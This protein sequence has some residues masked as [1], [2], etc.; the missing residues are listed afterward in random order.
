MTLGTDT[1]IAATKSKSM[2][3]RPLNLNFGELAKSLAKG[4][5]HA[6]TGRFEELPDDGIDALGAIGIDEYSS[7]SLTYKLL[8][9]SLQSSIYALIIDSKE[10]IDDD[11]DATQ[12]IK[13][14]EAH[15]ET[16]D[17]NVDFF[18]TPN[19]FPVI[20]AT[21][22]A[23]A[24]WLMLNGVETH[25]A[26]TIAARLPGYFP[27]ALHKEW[28][29]AASKYEI[30]R[31]DLMSPFL[32]SVQREAAWD[33]YHASLN[34]RLDESLFGE[35]FGL[36]QIYIPLNSYYDT[37]L[38]KSE[39]QKNGRHKKR[40]VVKLI[41][42]LDLWLDS[43]KKDDAIRAI[44]GGP[45][46][47]KS[48]FAK[49]YA[50][51]IASQNKNKVLFVPLHY[52]DPTRDFIEEIGR[53][54]RDEGILQANPLT[55]EGRSSDLLIILDGL[56]ELSSQ[57]RAAASTARNFVR[58]V[59]QTVDR[60][61]MH[62]LNLRVIFSGREV[63][64]QDSE[65]EF[66]LP[67]QVLTILPYFSGTKAD[68]D[69]DHS[70]YDDPMSLL[71]IDYRNIWWSNYSTLT[72]LMYEGIPPELDRSDLVEITSQPLLNYLL[73]LSFCR[74]KLN[75]SAG[76]NLNQIYE[77]LVQAVYERGYENG[78]KPESIRQLDSEDFGL[79]LEEIGLASWHGDGRTTTVSEIENYCRS[80]G[81]GE[82]LDA[83]QDGAKVGIT[84]LLAAFFFRQHGNRPQGDPTFIF[85][86]KSFGEYLAARRIV[87][88]MLVI[89][90]EMDRRETIGRGR[91]WSTTDALVYWAE[92]SG[93]TALSE[94]IHIFLRSEVMLLTKTQT[95]RAQSFFTVLLN[96]VLKFGMPIEK[97]NKIK[98]F[99]DALHNSRNSEEALLAALNAAA[100]ANKAIT[101]LDHPDATTF[102]SWFK[103]IQKQRSGPE[104]CLAASC[105]SWL[106]LSYTNLDF[107]DLYGADISYSNLS[108]VQGFRI[109]LSEATADHANFQ[110]AIFTEGYLS[111]SSFISA[112]FQ[113]AIL[114][115]ADFE[116]SNCV[117]ANF[118]KA[119]VN[120]AT[121]EEAALRGA[122]F[123]GSRRTE[124][125][126]PASRRRL[127]LKE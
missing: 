43:A 91:G 124:T 53:F 115:K 78:R 94:N 96:H 9:R 16:T 25:K 70:E 76:V 26:Q 10:Q 59:Q 68:R 37:V 90:D 117:K 101:K 49:I 126:F 107:A 99:H 113:N 35:P 36:R 61:N 46:S 60:L 58:S 6:I 77:D 20:T 32:N 4:I 123:R 38:S 45:G 88:S 114:A 73:A 62:S 92:T 34:Q 41:D 12:F 18:E 7:E 28:Q 5:G 47:G 66:R 27:L 105:L 29:S 71:D 102:G 119:D 30:I 3:S 93:P 24:E 17:V 14:L 98:T 82:Q 103:R 121:F 109:I 56:D 85:T 120:F 19:Q 110:D 80:G 125:K 65:S 15:I 33:I 51:H 40:V 100:R 64:M 111:Y 52:I 89:I 97:I 55:K 23:L 72:G 11:V 48:S 57:G 112:N 22:M 31:T 127:A 86:H 39:I 87:R 69:L 63:V 84:S 44:S 54:V 13:I 108:N 1:S 8:E 118:M 116:D 95:L 106:D 67:R 79:I 2:F 83:F 122:L 75:F 81:F 50:A 104:S 42:E 21:A 74:G